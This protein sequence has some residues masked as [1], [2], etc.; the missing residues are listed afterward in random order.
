MDIFVDESGD[1]EPHKGSQ[2]FVIGM[3]FSYKKNLTTINTQINSHY[4]HLWDNGWP[5]NAEIKATNLFNYK[6]PSYKIDIGNLKVNPRRCL[7]NI[8]SDINNLEIKAGFII[9]NPS[10]QGPM[11][12]YLHKEKIYNFLSKQLYVECFAFLRNPMNIHVD[13][14]NITLVKKEKR[15]HRDIQKLNLDYIGYIRHE[16]SFLFSQ[17]R[18]IDPDIE[19]SFENSKTNKGIQIADYLSWAV[20]RKYEGDSSWYNLFD[21]IERVEKEDN[22]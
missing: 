17:R 10:N 8:Y 15:V 7:Q 9:H 16:L 18:R 12:K 22:F 14:R 20:R 19:I 5:K 13:Q 4:R 6:R 21:K 3:V 11:L 1:M 2:F